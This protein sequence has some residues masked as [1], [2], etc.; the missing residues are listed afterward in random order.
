MAIT[1]GAE[2]G[3]TASHLLLNRYKPYSFSLQ[4]LKSVQANG[5]VRPG[6]TLFVHKC[7]CRKHVHA[8][9]VCVCLC[10]CAVCFAASRGCGI[11]LEVGWVVFVSWPLCWGAE[12]Q[13]GGQVNGI[14]GLAGGL[15]TANCISTISDKVPLCVIVLDGGS[16]GLPTNGNSL[17]GKGV[18]VCVC[19][20]QCL[21]VKLQTTIWMCWEQTWASDTENYLG[22]SGEKSY[23]K[24]LSHWDLHVTRHLLSPF[25]VQIYDLLLK[26]SAP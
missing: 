4:S 18:C 8:L 21:C 25:C 5:L 2:I 11:L 10:L 14:W 23:K 22:I 12:G 7:S 17:F 3:H 24:H 9:C 13:Q 6:L 19:V 15:E 20:P 26:S 16:W 1:K